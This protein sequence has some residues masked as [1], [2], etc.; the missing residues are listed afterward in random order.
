M[1]ARVFS[2]LFVCEG[3]SDQPLAAIV[4]RLFIEHDINLR[5][6]N[7]D[8]GLLP[9]VGKDVGSTV[10]AGLRLFGGSVDLVAV[11]R[12]A[13]NAGA[14]SRRLEIEKAIEAN[15]YNGI[16]LPVVPVRMTEA[17][18]LLDEAAIRRVAGVPNGKVKLGLPRHNRVESD[19]D[20]K[21]TLRRCLLE[22]SECTGRRREMVAKRF[23][24][25]RRQLLELLDVEGPVRELTSWGQLLDDVERSA[26][27]LAGRTQR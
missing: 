14:M 12:D 13:D 1:T 3:S 24:H 9:K 19:P 15:R 5:L 26:R 23:S 16:T 10:G 22:A 4:E 20:P 11:H 21:Q 7:P 18:L 6:S 2:G 27:I 25:H 17:W 8:F